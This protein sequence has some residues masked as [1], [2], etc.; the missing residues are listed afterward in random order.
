M[1]SN[2]RNEIIRIIKL[3]T[4]YFHRAHV[5]D[6]HVVPNMYI[7]ATVDREIFVVNFRWYPTTT[8]IKNTNI[9]Q[10][11]ILRGKL[12]FQYAEATKIKQ[13]EY[14]TDECFYERK[15]PDLRYI[16]LNTSMA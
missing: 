7:P 13:H 15:F 4:V 8:K 5:H 14:L 9:F 2:G 12:H 1:N 6:S 11:Q 16:L 10:H 3:T